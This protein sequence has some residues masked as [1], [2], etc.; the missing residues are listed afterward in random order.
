MIILTEL[1][2]MR[3]VA[4]GL[5]WGVVLF[6]FSGEKGKGREVLGSRYILMIHTKSVNC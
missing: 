4:L 2:I 6:I 5:C 3:L 1:R